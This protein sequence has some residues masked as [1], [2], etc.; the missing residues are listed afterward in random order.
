M[1]IAILGAVASV[2]FCALVTV[3]PAQADSG[4]DPK[5]VQGMKDALHYCERVVQMVVASQAFSPVIS[6]LPLDMWLPAASTPP[7]PDRRPFQIE[8]LRRPCADGTA[9]KQLCWLYRELLQELS[10]CE[11]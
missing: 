9:S 8:D 2:L 4:L 5:G 10:R 7:L 11:R 6:K 1:K 3:I